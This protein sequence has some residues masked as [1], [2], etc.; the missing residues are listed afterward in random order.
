MR[1]KPGPHV[2]KQSVRRTLALGIDL[3]TSGCKACIVDAHGM[4]RGSGTS[5]YPILTPRPLWTEQDPL[6]WLPAVIQ[7][8]RQAIYAARSI[9]SGIA[10]IALTSAAHIGVLLDRSQRPIRN[11]ILWN[12]QRSV[13]Q[14]RHLEAKAGR[15][16]LRRSCQAVSTTWTLPHLAWIRDNERRNW[17]RVRRVILSKDFVVE[18]MTGRAVTDRATAV[19]SQLWDVRANR[20]SD[21]LCDLVGLRTDQLPPVVAATDIVGELLPNVAEAIGLPSR[22]PVIVGTLDSATEL[23]AAGVLSD[24]ESMVRLAT[25]GGLQW[26]VNSPVADRHRITYPSPTSSMWY[27]QTATNTCAAAVEWARTLLSDGRLIS[28]E[29]WG[30]LAS[31]AP[32][33]ADGLIF[34]PHLAGERAPY[35]D[36]ALRGQ[37]SGLTMSHGR[38]H[39]ARAV[40]EGTAYSILDAMR[41]MPADIRKN[42]RPITVVGGGTRSRIWLDILANVLARPLRVVPQANSATGAALLGLSALEGGDLRCRSASSEGSTTVRP[43]QRAVQLY[44]RQAKVYMA[45]HARGCLRPQ[46][47]VSD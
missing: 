44:A 19:S 23:V 32:P 37:F 21:E 15:Q 2:V 13:N 34:H 38:A 46:S 33:G 28:L 40:Y 14:V 39:I 5:A 42:S 45:M 29:E 22:V 18:W 27:C 10:A 17:S 6:A 30:R 16:I 41:A 35:W 3:G 24:G 31:A 20:W 43:N 4:V 36:S 9:R 12:D 1:G 47:Y 11:A 8:S 26:V 25:A 7:A